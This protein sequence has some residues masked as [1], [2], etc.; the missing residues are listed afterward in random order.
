MQTNRPSIKHFSQNHVSRLVRELSS[1]ASWCEKEELKISLRSEASNFDRNLKRYEQ[2]REKRQQQLWELQTRSQDEKGK[3]SDVRKD[4][5]W[6]HDWQG[7][8]IRE[9]PLRFIQPG[10]SYLSKHE[11]PPTATSIYS[12]S[13][14][15]RSY[16]IYPC[17]DLR[18]WSAWFENDEV[19]LHQGYRF[20]FP[21]E[22][23]PLVSLIGG[24]R[25]SGIFMIDTRIAL[26]GVVA[27][28][29]N[30]YVAVDVATYV[31]VVECSAGDRN[32]DGDRHTDTQ[33]DRLITTW[34]SYCAGG[35]QRLFSDG[36]Q[37]LHTFAHAIDLPV[38]LILCCGAVDRFVEL[39]H[40]LTLTAVNATCQFGPNRQDCL[41]GSS[42]SYGWIKTTWP[43]I[44]L[45]YLS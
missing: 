22:N 28:G 1:F 26:Q 34:R 12:G 29:K 32:H 24:L 35:Q 27:I 33:Y 3:R 40:I 42:P 39:T 11:I 31:S 41:S 16:Q 5:E 43:I 38:H 14:A 9:R 21:T 8:F 25:F 19:T 6:V 17:P 15:A 23:P 30:G 13:P 36:Q 10:Q 20:W 2:E 4:A 45:E 37:G 18:Y 7:A 44:Q